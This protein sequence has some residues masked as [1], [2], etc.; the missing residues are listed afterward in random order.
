M[1]QILSF[2]EEE[3]NPSYN[4]FMS[5]LAKNTDTFPSVTHLTVPHRI[6]EQLR[7]RFPKIVSLQLLWAP[8]SLPGTW[9]TVFD[10]LLGTCTELESFFFPFI[11]TIEYNTIDQFSKSL[12]L[13]PRMRV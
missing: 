10:H 6:A 13:I 11:R 5:A 9:F 8:S 4:Y 2:P 1:L 3:S 7:P 12:C